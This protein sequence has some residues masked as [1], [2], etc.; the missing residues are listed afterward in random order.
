[1]VRTLAVAALVVLAIAPEALV[2]PSFQSLEQ[3]ISGA[4]KT[5]KKTLYFKGFVRFRL[6]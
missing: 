2:H 3:P 5:I 6:L 1:M 4:R